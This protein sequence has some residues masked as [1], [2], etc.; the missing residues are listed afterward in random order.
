MIPCI[1]RKMPI[2]IVAS[3]IPMSGT[4]LTNPLVDRPEVPAPEVVSSSSE[5]MPPRHKKPKQLV[6]R[7]RATPA[8]F[9]NNWGYCGL[10]GSLHDT[11]GLAANLLSGVAEGFRQSR[12]VG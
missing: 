1:F 4:E 7:L 2:R 9:D 12:L 5:R 10:K 3:D 11:V 6:A 8:C